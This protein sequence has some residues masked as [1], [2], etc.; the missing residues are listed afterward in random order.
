MV[1][2]FDFIIVTITQITKSSFRKIQKNWNTMW[3]YGIAIY[4][5]IIKCHKCYVS[6]ILQPKITDN[7]YM[8]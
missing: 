3:N 7:S 5:K 6:A 2:L 4:N 8:N 1:H